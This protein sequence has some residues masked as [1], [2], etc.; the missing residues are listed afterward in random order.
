MIYFSCTNLIFIEMK[1]FTI[2]IFMLLTFFI[3]SINIINAQ[4][5]CLTPNDFTAVIDANGIATI[6]PED[7]V[8]VGDNCDF[9][10]ITVAPNEF[11]CEDL[12]PQAV[13]ITGVAAGQ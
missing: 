6:N 13:T 11:T 9:S 7:V 5:E 8:T 12:G 2:G 1:K 4:N 10:T 3:G